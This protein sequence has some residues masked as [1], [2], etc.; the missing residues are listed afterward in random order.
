MRRDARRKTNAKYAICWQ[1]RTGNMK[2]A[3]VQTVDISDS[4][5]RIRCSCDLAPGL[6]VYIESKDILHQ[7]HA[8]Y[9]TVR[10]CSFREGHFD[11]G[12]EFEAEARKTVVLQSE[13]TIDYYE[14]LQISPKAEP[15]TIQR[16]YQFMASRFHPDNPQTGDLEKFLML[17]EAYEVLSD[18]HKRA[19]YDASRERLEAHAMP[20]FESAEFVLGIEG[21]VNRRLG[22]LSLL[23]NKRRT[24]PEHPKVSLYEL[25][26]AMGWPREY[27]D[28]ATWYLRSKQFVVREDNMDFSLTSAGVDF[29]ESNYVQIPIL[30]KLLQS[31]P[32]TATSVTGTAQERKPEAPAQVF[33]MEHGGSATEDAASPVA[34][35]A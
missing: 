12:L 9:S 21:E 20:I 25:E 35:L 3:E 22:I 11:V 17:K 19:V 8:G 32:V 14:F 33:I 16:I 28:F 5:M 15:P 13:S 10:H 7:Q 6:R 31:G 2:S 34:R 4:G 27:L 26:K 18:P 29:V 24:N 1:T 30:N 23:Y